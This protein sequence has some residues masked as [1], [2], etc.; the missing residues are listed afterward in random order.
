VLIDSVQSQA[1]RLEQALLRAYEEERLNVPVISVDFSVDFPD[2]GRITT[3]DAP[4][5]IADAILRDSVFEKNKKAIPFRET[6]QGKRFAS[7]TQRNATALYELCPTALIFGCWDSTGSQGGAGHKFQRALVSEIVGLDAEY[8][9]K[10]SSRI[11]PLGIRKIDIYKAGDGWTANVEKADRD[12]KKQPIKYAAAKSGKGNPSALNHG[13]VA[14]SLSDKD[15]EKRFIGGGV[16]ISK[17][18]QTTVLSL[19]ALR[20]LRFPQGNRYSVER[21]RAAHT[22]L[23][24]LA[25][26]AISLQQEYGYDL[27]SRCLLLAEETPTLELVTTSKQGPRFTV[28]ANK[29]IEILNAAIEAAL[30][31]GLIWQREPLALKPQE[32]LIEL[33]RQSRAA[34]EVEE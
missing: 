17:A 6:E 16:T 13:N 5:R 32:R 21:D 1:N 28:D 34:D 31:E 25:L 18:V 23:A 2:I 14:P 24:A 12:E 26:A 15:D 27:R 29:A 4:H 10:T 7:A 9:T 3:L 20:R 19:P 11:D 8:G 22:V 30:K 33:I